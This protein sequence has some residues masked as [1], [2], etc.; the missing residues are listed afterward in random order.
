MANKSAKNASAGGGPG[1][2]TAGQVKMTQTPVFGTRV[3]GKRG[4]SRKMSARSGRS[5]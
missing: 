5:R 2:Q 1:T 3:T 4:T